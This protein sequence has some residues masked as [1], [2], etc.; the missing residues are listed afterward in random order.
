MLNQVVIPLGSGGWMP[1]RYRQTM[2]FAMS[3]NSYLFIFDLGTGVSRFHSNI[4]Q[5]LIKNHDRIIVLISHYHF[6]H[7]VGLQYLPKFFFNKKVIIGAPG[8]SLY[9]LSA[10]QRLSKVCSPPYFSTLLKDFP[11]DL[12]IVDIEPGVFEIEQVKIEAKLLKHSDPTLG[13]RV[14]N[15]TYIADTA[16]APKRYLDICKNSSV[17]LHEAMFDFDGFQEVQKIMEIDHSHGNQVAELAKDAGVK[18]LILTHLNPSYS[19]G[20]LNKMLID[21]KTTFPNTELSND[22]RPIEI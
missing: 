14:G 12:K 22:L 8:K 15:V 4:G 7:I 10:K 13:Y 2:C 21:A 6:D 5:D 19:R 17:L 16:Y 20:R 3:I 1:N 9:N 11:M 18:K